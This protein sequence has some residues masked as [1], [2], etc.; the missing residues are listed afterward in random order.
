[1]M[2]Y[3]LSQSEIDDAIGIFL[4]IPQVIENIEELGGFRKISDGAA[5][6]TVVCGHDEAI[7][8]S[9]TSRDAAENSLEHGAISRTG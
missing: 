7:V 3:I 1:M 5:R 2:T 9:K 4:K 6:N 8:G